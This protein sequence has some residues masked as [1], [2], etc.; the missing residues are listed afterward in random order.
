MSAK[1]TPEEKKLAKERNLK[2]V[3][4]DAGGLEFSGCVTAEEQQEV[5]RFLLAFL[6]KRAA[7]T[8]DAD[9]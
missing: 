3:T 7:R 9:E 2:L 1:Y 6:D 4:I 5:A 8:S